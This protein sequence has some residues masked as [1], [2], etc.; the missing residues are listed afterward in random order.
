MALINTQKNNSSLNVG[1]VVATMNRPDFIIRL[2]EY[3]NSLQSPHPIY[4]TD[5]SDSVI[6]AKIKAEISQLENR[7]NVT[8]N[9]H[10]PGDVLKCVFAA[11]SLVKEKY[12]CSIGDDD[13]QVP[14]T[15]TQCAQFLEDNPDYTSAVGRSVT[16]KVVGNGAYGDLKEIHDYPRFPMELESAQERLINYLGKQ[17]SS[18]IASVT[19]TKPFIEYYKIATSNKDASFRGELLPSCLMII[20]GKSKVIDSIGLVRQIHDSHFKVP[21]IFDKLIEKDYPENYYHFKDA[22]VSALIN[23]DGVDRDKAE[24]LVKKSYWGH[25]VYLLS[26]FREDY[27]FNSFSTKTRKPGIRT[28]IATYSPTAK[29][30]YRR[31]RPLLT[32]KQ[33]LHYDVMQPNSKYYKDFRPILSSLTKKDL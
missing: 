16:F 9:Y 14:D 31:L 18:I 3:Y 23:K 15:L 28:K 21:D 19:R 6:A 26:R 4:I 24:Y 1:I 2:L 7:L 27:T 11:L 8:Y 20:D 10:P 33:Q 13:F 22:L 30:I 25:L 29:L 12:V 17:H 5:S 32:N